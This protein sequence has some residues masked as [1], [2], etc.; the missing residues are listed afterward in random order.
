MKISEALKQFKRWK[1]SGWSKSE[2]P[3]SEALEVAIKTLTMEEGCD[4]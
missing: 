1:E 3:S 2:T 4:E